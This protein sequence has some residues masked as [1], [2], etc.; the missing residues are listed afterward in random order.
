VAVVIVPK[1]KFRW[2]K[3]KEHI[4]EWSKPDADWVSCFCSV[5]GSSLPVANDAE[6]LAVPAGLIDDSN[7]TL[8]LAAHV[9]VGSKASWDEIA[10]TCPQYQTA[11]EP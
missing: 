1:Q 7:Q 4:S 6:S 11:F 3:G 2:L 10:G 5:C 8:R 9:W